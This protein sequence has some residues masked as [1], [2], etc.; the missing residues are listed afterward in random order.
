MISRE[1]DDVNNT[2]SVLMNPNE[3]NCYIDQTEFYIESHF[4]NEAVENVLGVKIKEG[5]TGLEDIENSDAKI[6]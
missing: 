6:F 4:K 1:K 5:I 2:K 3:K